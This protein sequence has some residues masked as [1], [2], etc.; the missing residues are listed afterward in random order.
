MAARHPI[1]ANGTD[2]ANDEYDAILR[3]LGSPTSRIESQG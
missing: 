2:N 1:V 3:A